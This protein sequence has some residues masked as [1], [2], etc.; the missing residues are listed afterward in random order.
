MK[1]DIKF[2]NNFLSRIRLGNQTEM[3]KVF[4]GIAAMLFVGTNGLRLT[5]MAMK[6]NTTDHKNSSSSS[7][8]TTPHPTTDAAHT[9]QSANCNQDIKYTA[10]QYVSQILRGN[11]ETGPFNDHCYDLEYLKKDDATHWIHAKQDQC[12]KGNG[13]NEELCG[14]LMCVTSDD[15]KDALAD[16]IA[17]AAEHA[18]TTTC[19][20]NTAHGGNSTNHTASANNTLSDAAVASKN[21]LYSCMTDY[22]FFDK[23]E[24]VC[25]KAKLDAMVAGSYNVTSCEHQANLLLK[26]N[27]ES[28]TLA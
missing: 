25:K 5:D 6:A 18:Y 13:K 26:N 16:S 15:D 23:Y 10:L 8:T 4:A 24:E 1:R 2:V 11:I 7:N 19:G 21:T 3:K 28:T 14:A 17:Q 22:A 20:N 27:D 9:P 12:V